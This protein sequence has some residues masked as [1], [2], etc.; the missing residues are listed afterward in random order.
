MTM[1][2]K[3]TPPRKYTPEMRR[4]FIEFVPGHSHKEIAEEFNRRFDDNI[5]VSTVKGYIANHKLN[6]GRTGRFEQGNT[7]WSK[8]RKMSPEQYEKCMGTMFKAGERSKTRE[9][10]GT[11][12]VDKYGYTW[13]K[14]SDYQYD[15]ANPRNNWKMK[16]RLVYEQAYGPIPE[17]I[18]IIFLDGDK[19]NFNLDNLAPVTSSTICRMNQNGL[20]SEDPEATK[21]GI[22]VAELITKISE[23]ERGKKDG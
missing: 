3:R 14:V 22:A 19:T 6:T 5:K 18:K 4:F 7:P 23:L 15:P 1:D 13:V 20:F 21:S 2:R 16:H 8:G 11:E 10:V 17:G 12:N 9:V